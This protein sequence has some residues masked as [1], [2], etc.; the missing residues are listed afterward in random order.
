MGDDN[1]YGSGG[2][3][4]PN[5]L[6]PDPAGSPGARLRCGLAPGAA[7]RAFSRSSTFGEGS[8]LA[9]NLGDG[10]DTTGAY[11]GAAAIPRAW[12]D[13]LAMRDHIESYARGLIR[14]GV[15]G[16]ITTPRS[17]AALPESRRG[18]W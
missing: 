13:S 17:P 4:W 3:A 2:D 18:L 9:V 10:A 12:L 8:L 6:L 15:T 7:L 16:G 11:Y 14:C 1:P 5:R